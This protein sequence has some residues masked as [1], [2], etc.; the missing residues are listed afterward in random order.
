MTPITLA[1]LYP[2]E[3]RL[4][5]IC[6]LRFKPGSVLDRVYHTQWIIKH[7]TMSA[8]FIHLKEYDIHLK[9]RRNEMCCPLAKHLVV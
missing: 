2:E 5:Y 4:S 9:G 3:Q 1:T 6:G 7:N 8:N